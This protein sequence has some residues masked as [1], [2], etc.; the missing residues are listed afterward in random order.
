MR[1]KCLRLSV[2]AATILILL[3]AFILAGCVPDRETAVSGTAVSGTAVNQPAPVFKAQSMTQPPTA[4]AT[5]SEMRAPEPSPNPEMLRP[6]VMPQLTELTVAVPTLPSQTCAATRQQALDIQA[7]VDAVSAENLLRTVQ[8]LENFGTRHTFSITKSSTT[9]IGAART[10][11]YN[12]FVRMGNNRLQVSFDHFPVYASDGTSMD[13]QNV[14]AT[15]PGTDTDR[16][17]LVLMAHYD[18]RNLGI[19]DGQSVAPGAND[20]ASGVAVLLETA[21]LLSPY[22]WNQTIIFVAFAGEEQE[23]QGSNYYIQ[24][25]LAKGLVFEAAIN[26]DIVGGRPGIAQRV[27]VFSAGPDDSAHHQLARYMQLIGTIYLPIFPV[28]LQDG[29]DRDG[30]YSDQREFAN[31]NIPALRVIQ[32]E[33]DTA[34]Q[35]SSQDTFDRIDKNYLLRVTQLNLATVAN[36]ISAPSAPAIPQVRQIND[37]GDYRVTWQPDPQASSYLISFR[38]VGLIEFSSLRTICADEVGNFILTGL[39]PDV[40]YAISLAAVDVNGRIGLFS[41]E[42]VITGL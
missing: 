40:V 24:E 12:E 36:A 16:G 26:F 2:S 33:E 6:T 1:R 31:A 21:R 14:V 28:E 38:P 37:R 32:S 10:W 29:L 18:S 19:E 22:V 41:P 30:R 13:A 3:S 23:T 17:A 8:T 9:G 25:S 39:E 35:H 5:P 27:R 42:I 7:I 20:N 15:L 11:L 34:V 4:S